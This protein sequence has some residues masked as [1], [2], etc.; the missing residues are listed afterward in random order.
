MNR[1]VF[2]AVKRSKSIRLRRT[3]DGLISESLAHDIDSKLDDKYRLTTDDSLRI[4][5]IMIALDQM[6]DLQNGALALVST[7]CHGAVYLTLGRNAPRWQDGK[8]SSRRSKTR[9]KRN[10]RQQLLPSFSG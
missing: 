10:I 4:K 1:A 2:A 8:S 7:G 9:E 6:T 3:D 5:R